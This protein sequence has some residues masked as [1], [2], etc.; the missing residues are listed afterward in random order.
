MKTKI[1][2]T[3]NDNTAVNPARRLT[4]AE[5][6]NEQLSGAAWRAGLQFRRKQPF[7]TRGCYEFSF[8]CVFP[9]KLTAAR[10]ER[11]GAAEVFG[12]QLRVFGNQ[13][14]WSTMEGEVAAQF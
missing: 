7:L 5:C 12:S 4:R 6:T 3:S 10:L 14:G 11:V 9:S 13:Q 2:L 1:Q 8:V